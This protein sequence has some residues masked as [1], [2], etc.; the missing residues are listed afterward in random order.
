MDI[1]K[2]VGLPGF[3]ESNL[4]LSFMCQPEDKRDLSVTSVTGAISL[5]LSLLFKSEYLEL[6]IQDRAAY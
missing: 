4:K 5:L 2:R 6:Q 1:E 3:K